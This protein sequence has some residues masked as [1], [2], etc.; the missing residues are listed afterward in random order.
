MR[1]AFVSSSPFPE[2]GEDWGD[3][4]EVR[5]ST[6]QATRYEEAI[7]SRPASSVAYTPARRLTLSGPPASLGVSDAP[8]TQGDPDA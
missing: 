2:A 4:P 3:P 8:G 7:N 1:R 5:L 6:P